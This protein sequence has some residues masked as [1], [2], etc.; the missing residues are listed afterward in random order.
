[1]FLRSKRRF[2]NGK[3]HRYYSVVENRRLPGNRIVQRQVL[4]LGEINDTQEATWRRTL[5]VFDEQRRSLDQLSLFPEDR[6][7]PPDA[8]NA[9]SLRMSELKLR[10]MRSYGNCWLGVTLWRQLGLD[11]FWSDRL[12]VNSLVACDFFTK[13]IITP[14]GIRTAYC[15]AFIHV[16]T[17]KVFL[18][19][20]T[21]HPNDSWV[22]QQARNALM[23]LEDQQLEARF[24]I[25]DRDSKF[26]AAFRRLFVSA[27]IRCL[28]T[29]PMAP[30][31]NAFAEAWIGALKRECL[32][33]FLCFSLG[34]LD[35]IGQEYVRFYNEHRPHQGLGNLTIPL[36][37]TESR[38][39][40]S[41]PVAPASGSIRC[42][43]FLGGLL[44][45]YYRAAA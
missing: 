9:L 25:H 18:S 14:I 10:R 7:I 22:Q 26:S 3:W 30:D 44:R 15:L 16:G 1:M 40:S 8:V 42:Q 38:A 32:N 37:A 35:H 33:H 19:P 43:R 21:Y 5:E 4:Y 11:R 2:K 31:A 45:H 34:H 29:P 6:E 41:L 27:E 39:E 28:R 12:H 13:S 20:A 23:W 24:L 36:A 17:R